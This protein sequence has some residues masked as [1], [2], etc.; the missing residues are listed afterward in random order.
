MSLCI[1]E[2]QNK[3]NLIF[4]TNQNST[5]V[6]WSQHQCHHCPLLLCKEPCFPFAQECA[7]PHK[8]ILTYNNFQLQGWERWMLI[9]VHRCVIVRQQGCSDNYNRF[10][11]CRRSPPR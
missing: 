4:G 6:C 8:G 9:G 1:L 5:I 7:P 10:Q 2:M 3:G 11:K